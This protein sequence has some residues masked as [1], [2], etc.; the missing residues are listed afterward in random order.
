MYTLVSSSPQ[1]QLWQSS[2]GW[3][4]YVLNFGNGCVS[5]WRYRSNFLPY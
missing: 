1:S 5:W 2:N 4:V 3:C